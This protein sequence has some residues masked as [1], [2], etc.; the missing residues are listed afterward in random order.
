MR[1][2][3]LIR[4]RRRR[5]VWRSVDGCIEIACYSCR[6]DGVPQGVVVVALALRLLFCAF[7]LRAVPTQRMQ[8]PLTRVCV[9][10][11]LCW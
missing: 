4:D 11:S 2:T 3:I 5:S 10:V 6:P 1:C 8:L 9:C 7:H